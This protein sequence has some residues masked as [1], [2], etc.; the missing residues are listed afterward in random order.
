MKLYTKL[1]D[2]PV[3]HRTEE[4]CRRAIEYGNGR[5]SDF[6]DDLRTADLCELAVAC[7]KSRH[8]V[9]RVIAIRYIPSSEVEI[10]KKLARDESE[11]GKI[12]IAAIMRIPSMKEK[13]FRETKNRRRTSVYRYDDTVLVNCGCFFGTPLEFEEQVERKEYDDPRRKAY[14]KIIEKIKQGA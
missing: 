12:R 3:E 14:E 9:D 5:L 10:L 8:W 1:S 11:N 13:N 6:P 4:M 2:V 7:D